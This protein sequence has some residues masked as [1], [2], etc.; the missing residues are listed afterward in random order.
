MKCCSLYILCFIVF[1]TTLSC[2][3]PKTEEEEVEL[4]TDTTTV[5]EAV[6]PV[7]IISVEGKVT[8]INLGK[9]GYTAEIKTD[10]GETYF[11]T[12]SIPN[13]NV[14]AQYKSFKTGDK[15]KV[16]GESWKLEMDNYITV[17]EI[18]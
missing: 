8:S 15:V 14:P 6:Q 1:L 18:L 11:L 4:M 13:L 7:K 5:H 3:E 12:V 10:G 2:N 9:D 16:K 17:R